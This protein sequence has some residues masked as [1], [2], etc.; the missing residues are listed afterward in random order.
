MERAP[1]GN[2]GPVSVPVELEAL[3]DEVAARRPQALLLSVNEDERP[4]AVAV[5]VTWDAGR[6]RVGAGSRTS[7]NVAGRPG[8]TVLWPALEPGAYSLIVDGSATVEG[9]EAVVTP[10]RAVLHRTPVGAGGAD[11]DAPSCITVL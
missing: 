7:A 4:H 6:L 3:A 1:G 9:S 10:G 2:V 5:E 8:V 11:P